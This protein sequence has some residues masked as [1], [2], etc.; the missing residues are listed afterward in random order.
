MYVQIYR[1]VKIPVGVGAPPL[2]T[3]NLTYHLNIVCLLF[4]MPS[5]H[6]SSSAFIVSVLHLSY[7]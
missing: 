4:G 2:N 3:H 7:S 6:A 5:L 1:M